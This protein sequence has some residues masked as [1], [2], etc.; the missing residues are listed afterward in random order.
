MQG[1]D[2]LKGREQSV[3]ARAPKSDAVGYRPDLDGLRAI[4]V[5][6]VVFY[7]IS[8][9]SVPGGYLGVDVFFV[10]SGFLITS[11]LWRD[12]LQAKFSIVAFY[13]RRIRRIMPALIALLAVI[14]VFS[15]VILLPSDLIGY[16]KSLLASLA[17]VANIY[18]WR[19]TNYFTKASEM[20]PLLHLWSLGVEEQFYILFPWLIAGLARISRRASIP[21]LA[22]IVLASLSLDIVVRYH[23]GAVPAFFLLPT[24]AWELGIGSI[25]AIMP[26]NLRI[27]TW[28]GQLAASIG[29]VLILFGLFATRQADATIP[30]ALPVTVGTAIVI[31]AGGLKSRPLVNRALEFPPLVFFGLI[32]Y[33][34]YLWHWPIIV[35]VRYYLVR[36]FTPVES[37]AVVLLSAGCAYLSWRFVERPFRNKSMPIVRVRWTAASAMGVMALAAVFLVHSQGLPGRLKGPAIIVNEA[38]D[39]FYRCPVSDLLMFGAS[40]GCVMNLPTREPQDADVVLLGNSYAQMYAPLVGSILAERDLKG[41]LVPLNGCL[42]TVQANLNT[43]CIRA[44]NAN[45]K[46]VLALPRAKTVVIALTWYNP[47]GLVGPNGGALNDNEDGA[48]TAALDDLA[49]RLRQGGRQVVIIGPIAA[50]HWNLASILSRDLTFGHPIERR[51]YEPSHEFYSDYNGVIQHFSNERNVRFVRPDLVQ[52]GTEQCDYIMDGR[53]LFADG[54]HIAARELYRFR[55]QFDAELPGPEPSPTPVALK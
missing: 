23:G 54:Y 11:I 16:G 33:S 38:V 44:A 32:S 21:V 20:K 45:L 18:F 53:P 8:N 49:D 55:K 2:I 17:F 9:S 36:D 14:T 46:A 50:P 35:L 6:S 27:P 52:C 48:L 19:D 22:A 42:P 28:V 37:G 5:W 34:L 4:A 31:F 15:A 41:L 30:P 26:S 29:A 3:P 13:D 1:V 24:R 39:T 12:S 40:R 47:T 7:H 25:L 10:L 51:L 43:G